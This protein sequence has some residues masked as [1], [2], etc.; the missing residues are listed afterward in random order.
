MAKVRRATPADV[1]AMIE[2]GR[3]LALESP[4]YRDMDF[5]AGKL[6][7]LGEQLFAAMAADHT[8]LLVAERASQ[9][10]GMMVVVTVERWFG[11]DRFVSDLTLY[12]RPEHRG[13]FAFVRLVMAAEAWATERGVRDAAFG[14]STEIHA[15]RTVRAY[16][17]LGYTLSG[18][19][20]TKTL[21][22]DGH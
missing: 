5:D 22:A 8:C 11:G 13:G 17:R 6:A 12:V 10:V 16:R 14:V 15:K 19:T 2:M 3:A 20:L 7:A 9:V 1:P 18:Y 4:K 21:K